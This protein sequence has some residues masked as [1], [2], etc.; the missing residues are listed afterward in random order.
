MA[1]ETMVGVF[2]SVGAAERAKAAL[3]ESGVESDRIAISAPL[4]E[5]AIAAE[6]PGQ[7]YENQAYATPDAAQTRYNEAVRTGGCVL[8]VHSASSDERKRI[9]DIMRRTGAR[10]ALKRPDS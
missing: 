5:D 9:E 6:A 7:S 4:T 3:M 8:T 2:A 1:S 10:I